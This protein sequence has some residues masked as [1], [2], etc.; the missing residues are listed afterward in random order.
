V[1]VVVGIG[2]LLIGDW[3]TTRLAGNTVEQR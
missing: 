1:L 3:F 2:F